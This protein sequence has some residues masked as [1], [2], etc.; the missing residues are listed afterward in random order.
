MKL[1]CNFELHQK[2]EFLVS[3]PILQCGY[4]QAVSP[5][6]AYVQAIV[7]QLEIRLLG[8]GGKD[9]F[10]KNTLRSATCVEDSWKHGE[11]NERLNR[12]SNSRSL[13]TCWALAL[14]MYPCCT[15]IVDVAIFVWFHDKL[16]LIE[17]CC[18][19]AQGFSIVIYGIASIA[20]FVLV[21]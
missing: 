8:R 13:S 10:S 21:P 16:L 9:Y 5:T 4:L 1:R 15:H 2:E 7:A 20:C 18:G 17:I 12:L 19:M 3:G 11:G 14:S 6:V